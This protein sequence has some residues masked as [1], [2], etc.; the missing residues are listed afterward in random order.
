MTK[1]KERI[2]TYLCMYKASER[3][4]P[5]YIFVLQRL[6]KLGRRM[7]TMSDLA[8]ELVGEI[9]ARVPITS[10]RAVRSTCK[11]WDSLSG[12]LIFDK[13]VARKQLLGFMTMDYKLC[14]VR[15]DLQ[16]VRNGFIDI[17]LNEIERFN[18]NKIR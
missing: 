18:R 17:S 5:N 14:S 10:L 13:A 9:L 3:Q 6:L 12:N 4:N 16:G 7:T 11:S 2:G 1:K 15:F 8:P